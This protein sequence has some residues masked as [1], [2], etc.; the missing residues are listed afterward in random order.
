M[1]PYAIE[2][3][4]E[5]PVTIEQVKAHCR[6]D[7]DLDDS[8]TALITVYIRAAVR[9]AESYQNRTIAQ[10]TMGYDLTCFPDQIKLI[11]NVQEIVSIEYIDINGVTQTLPED[12]YVLD[13]RSTPC[14]IIPAFGTSFPAVKRQHNSVTVTYTGGYSEIPEETQLAILFLA[15]HWYENREPIVTGTIVQNIPMTVNALLSMNSWGAY[16]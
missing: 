15:A 3:L 1:I 11:P 4:S 13:N 10:A 14:R 9:Y 12:Q 5:L 16:Y 8:E 6:I 7:H 2:K